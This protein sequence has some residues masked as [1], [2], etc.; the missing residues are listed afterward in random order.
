MGWEVEQ[1]TS[2]ISAIKEKLE[3]LMTEIGSQ[4]GVF[5][6]EMYKQIEK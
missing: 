5:I 1:D 3:C 4:G 2:S 6:C